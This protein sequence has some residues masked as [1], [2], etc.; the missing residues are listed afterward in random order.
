MPDRGIKT[1]LRAI[2]AEFVKTMRIWFSYPIMLVFW[3]VFPLLWVLPYIFQ[4]RA[5][6]GSGTSEAFRQLTGS[7]NYLAFVLI[8]AMI[9]TF[10]FSA[11]W[12]V[13]NSLREETY[14]GTMEYIIASPTHPLVIL[15]GKTL[16]EWTWSTVMVLFQALII[17]LFFG[18]QFTLAKI[19]PVLLLVILLMIG[20]YGFAIAFAGFTLLIKEVHGWVHTLEWIFFLFSP[21]RYPVQVNPIT[22][23]VSTLIPLTWALIAIRGIILLNRT[24]VNLY[25]TVL[26]L[27]LMDIVLLTAG[28]FL[29]IYLERKTRRDGTVGMH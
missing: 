21:I 5:L 24:E 29:F 15:I 2:G 28:Y 14:W 1:E 17:A 18:V 23:A 13:G 19:L 6:V 7:G 3:A 10:V 26:V 27:T 8:G 4:G 20:F 25:Q 9:S 16:A 11:L 22:A 12:G